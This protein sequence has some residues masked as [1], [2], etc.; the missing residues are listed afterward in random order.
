MRNQITTTRL[1]ASL[2]VPLLFACGAENSGGGGG[3]VQVPQCD[4]VGQVLSSN[5]RPNGLQVLK[6]G[7]SKPWATILHGS[8]HTK[9]VVCTLLIQ[10]QASLVLHQVQ[11]QP[12]TQTVWQP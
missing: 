7:K 6:V 5:V 9:M 1:L 4:T 10:K 3:F 11:T 12:L 2:V 8:N